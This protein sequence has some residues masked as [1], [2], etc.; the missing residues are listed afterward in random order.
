MAIDYILHRPITLHPTLRLDFPQA[1]CW[2]RSLIKSCT[3][4]PCAARPLGQ[5]LPRRVWQRHS[6][7]LTCVQEKNGNA[8]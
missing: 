1:R 2:L 3:P 4:P 8:P 7:W 5:H 6:A